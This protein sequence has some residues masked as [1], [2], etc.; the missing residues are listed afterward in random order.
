MSNE[1]QYWPIEFLLVGEANYYP[2]VCLGN[3]PQDAIKTFL[4]NYSPSMGTIVAIRVPD[5]GA[6][7]KLIQPG[8]SRNKGES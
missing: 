2:G 1:S 7:G 5:V 3:D 4:E 6:D 8:H